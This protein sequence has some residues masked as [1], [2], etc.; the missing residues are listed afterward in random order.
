MAIVFGPK[1]TSSIPSF[2][3][4][5]ELFSSV[6]NWS[7]VSWKL[8]GTKSFCDSSLL[9]RHSPFQLLI[10]N[11]LVQGVLVD[12]HKALVVFSDD[13]AVVNL[14]KS[15]L[16]ARVSML[17]SPVSESRVSSH[18]A[19]NRDCRWPAGRCLLKNSSIA[20]AIRL[21][22]RMGGGRLLRGSCKGVEV[23]SQKF[24]PEAGENLRM[25]EIGVIETHLN[26]CRVDV[27]VVILVRHP[28]KQKRGGK[29][30]GVD[31]CRDTPL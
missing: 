4:S 6:S 26:F 17:V 22:R 31:S 14:H 13:E 9:F 2:S 10:H 19:R 7:L 29:P 25:N 23:G 28:D 12:N 24:F 5:C 1:G 3:K 20:S 27:D 11:S 15:S 30:A 16:V 21:S 8:S 18:E